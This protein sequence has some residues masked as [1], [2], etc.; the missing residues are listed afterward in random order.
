[1]TNVKNDDRLHVLVNELFKLLDT[2]EVSENGREFHPTLINSC[3][4]AHVM[5]LDEIL[6]EIRAILANA[7]LEPLA[8]KDG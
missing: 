2:V 4:T 1:M 6:P 8:R 3:R 7:S 5:R